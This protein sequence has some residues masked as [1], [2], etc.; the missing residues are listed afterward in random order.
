MSFLSVQMVQSIAFHPYS[1]VNVPVPAL[2]QFLCGLISLPLP[3]NSWDSISLTVFIVSAEFSR[4]ESGANLSITLFPL[5]TKYS[6]T[7]PS[8]SFV[9]VAV[10]FENTFFPAYSS[11]SQERAGSRAASAWYLTLM[12]SRASH[13]ETPVNIGILLARPA[14]CHSLRIRRICHAAPAKGML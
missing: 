11:K 12:G 1:F 8:A 3:V 10:M 2:S 13:V 4:S 9:R 14:C 6:E 7:E 5:M